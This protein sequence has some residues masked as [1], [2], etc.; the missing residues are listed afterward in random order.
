MK[1]LKTKKCK[2]NGCEKP[3]KA[4]GFCAMHLMRIE[5]HGDP[6]PV[7]STHNQFEFCTINGCNRKHKSLGYCSLHYERFL[8]TGEVGPIDKKIADSGAGTTTLEGYRVVSLGNGEKCLEHRL[9]ME[10]HLGRKLL[11]NE[12]VHH[13]NG[14]RSDNR[15]ENLELW[16][17]FQP[18]GQRPQDLIK[19]AKDIFLQYGDLIPEDDAHYW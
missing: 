2:I 18:S 17:T 11:N 16:I 12:N 3:L 10:Q 19:Y 7:Q 5:R 1:K 4:K 13:K 14:N 15:V 6:G 9:I 8:R